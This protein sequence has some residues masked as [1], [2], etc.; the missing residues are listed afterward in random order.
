M[1]WTRV[2]GGAHLGEVGAI[3]G[4]EISRLARSSADLS[5]LL[6]LARLTDTLVVDADGIYDLGDFND[7]MLLGLKNQRSEAELHYL[8]GRLQGAKRAAAERGELR[9]PLPV[10]YIYDDEGNIVID[11]DGEVQAAMTDVFAAFRAGRIRLSGGGRVQG[12]AVPASEPTEECGPA[13]CA[14]AG[15]LTPGSLEHPRTTPATPAPTCTAATSSNKVVEPDGTVRTKDHP[16]CPGRSGRWSSTTTIPA[17]SAGR[18]TWPTRP[19]W[20]RT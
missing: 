4:L 19:A 7:R 2:L 16:T 14:G 17:T 15:S 18:T 6:E 10:G 13:S 9:I 11:P 5:R 8:A 20:P 1:A 12:P 3:F